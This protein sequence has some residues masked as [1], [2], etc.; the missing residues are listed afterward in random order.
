M[1]IV[2]PVE[3]GELGTMAPENAKILLRA[4]FR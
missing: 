2:H 1:T 4:A 3:S